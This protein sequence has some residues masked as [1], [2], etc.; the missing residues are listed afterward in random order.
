MNY[1]ITKDFSSLLGY[2]K[3][4]PTQSMKILPYISHTYKRIYMD[5]NRKAYSPWI[6]KASMGIANDSFMN[7]NQNDA[8]EFFVCL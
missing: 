4:N 7:F 2:D 5:C 6:C 8:H 3:T 1:L